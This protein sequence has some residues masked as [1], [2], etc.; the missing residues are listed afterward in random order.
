MEGYNRGHEKT[1]IFYLR[2]NRAWVLHIFNTCS[3]L[4]SDGCHS[5]GHK[6]RGNDYANPYTG[7]F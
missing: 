6:D 7:A 2:V 5:H 4:H 3:H 1:L